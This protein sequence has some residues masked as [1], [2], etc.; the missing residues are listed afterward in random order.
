MPWDAWVWRVE[1]VMDF[2]CKVPFKK[3][4]EG[5]RGPLDHFCSLSFS[6]RNCS[7]IQ[8]LCWSFSVLSNSK[9]LQPSCWFTLAKYWPHISQ[10]KGCHFQDNL[11]VTISR[12]SRTMIFLWAA[13]PP[14]L[15][16][17]FGQDTM[18]WVGVAHCVGTIKLNKI[19]V[20]GR[21]QG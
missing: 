13:L 6:Y 5:N 19:P 10:L 9:V 16:T 12:I 20:K 21:W 2:R 17:T 8:G 18:Q 3:E 15:H 1:C 4:M 7:W 11:S 14:P